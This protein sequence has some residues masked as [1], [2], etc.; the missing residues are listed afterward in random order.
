[1]MEDICLGEK[2]QLGDTA[3]LISTA[4]VMQW[5]CHSEDIYKPH[6]FKKDNVVRLHCQG[7]SE[8]SCIWEVFLEEL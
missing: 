2:I 8:H 3:G 4:P 7:N 1:M 5:K 6:L